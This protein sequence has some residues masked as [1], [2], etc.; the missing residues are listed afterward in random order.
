MS[1]EKR[2]FNIIRPFGPFLLKSTV[3][4]E[5]H[6]ILLNSAYK[7]RKNK[8]L[9]KTNDYRKSLAGNLAEEYSYKNAL[10]EKEFSIVK[11]ELTWL[12]SLYTKQAKLITGKKN[13]ERDSKNILMLEPLWVNFMKQGEWN[14]YHSHTGDISC[15]LYLKVPKEI[16]NENLK[17]ETSSQ[18]NTPSAGKIEWL[19][20]DSIGYDNSAFVA[21]PKEKDI[22]FFPA[23]LK[24]MVYP[25]KSKTERISMSVN[26]ADK[27]TALNNL[28]RNGEN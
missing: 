6:K 1:L 24:H 7:I 21:T 25:F 4:D 20:G 10:T 28:Q 11:E 9:K 17:S 5:T 27:I 14:P 12:A 22:Y 3:S 26:F 19:H 16:D 15:V 8:K 23:K 18:S 2:L 13:L